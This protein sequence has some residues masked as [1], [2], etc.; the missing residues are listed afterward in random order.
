MSERRC[1]DSRSKSVPE[2]AGTEKFGFRGRSVLKIAEWWRVLGGTRQSGHSTHE[3]GHRAKGATTFL[4]GKYRPGIRACAD[5]AKQELVP[6]PAAGEDVDI[7]RCEGISRPFKYSESL[8]Q[9]TP[10]RIR[11]IQASTRKPTARTSPTAPVSVSERA[12]V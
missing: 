1:R 3:S 5:R 6:G 7:V 12:S 9:L 11:S 10:Q 8:V 4:K 2:F